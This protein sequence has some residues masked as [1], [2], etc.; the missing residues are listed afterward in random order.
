M[1]NFFPL[2][3]SAALLN[4]PTP[5]PG[6]WER[7]LD[8]NLSQWRIYQSHRHVP[9]DQGRPPTNAQGQ[10]LPPIGYDK[11]EANGF[12]VVMQ[13]KASRCCASAARF[14]AASSRARTTPTTT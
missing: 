4:H 6:G 5:P 1:P 14:T 9:G 3:L 12:S 8:K 10:P 11:N 7:L 13:G 2:L